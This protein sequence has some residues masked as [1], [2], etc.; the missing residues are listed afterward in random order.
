MTHETRFRILALAVLAGCG[1]QRAAETPDPAAPAATKSAP[2]TLAGRIVLA[3]ELAGARRGSVTVNAWRAGEA[4]R[5]GAQPFLSRSYEIGDPDWSPGEGLLTR[6]FGLC[7][8]DRVGDPARV[9]PDE[10]EIEACFD[11][12]GLLGTREGIVRG[13]AH[14]RNGAKDVVVRVSP[15][16]ETAQPPGSRRKGG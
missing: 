10:L 13:S 4:G 3:G 1:C 16:T 6:Y 2:A 15:Q 11:P 8:A 7:E 9:L 12:D 5:A 14:A